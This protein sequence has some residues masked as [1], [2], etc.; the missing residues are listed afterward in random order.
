MPRPLAITI[1]AAL[2]LALGAGPASALTIQAEKAAV[3]TVGGMQKGAWS[4]WSNGEVGDYVRFEKGGT[5]EIVA[6]AFGS[7]AGGGWPLMSVRIDGEALAQATVDKA[8]AAEYPFK[9]RIEPGTHLVTIGFENDLVVGKEDRNLYLVQIEVRPTEGLPEPAAAD[10]KE[11]DAMQEKEEAAAVA[12]TRQAI[13]KNRRSALT[14]RVVDRDGRAVPGASVTAEQTASDFLFGCNIYMFDRFGKPEQNAAYQ[15]RFEELF[16]YATVGFYWTSY[17]TERGKPQYP[18]TDKVVAWCEAR[19][20][21]MKGH[22]LLWADPQGGVPPWSKGQPSA[23]LQKQRVFDILGRY[24]DKITFWEVVNEAC[25]N[26]GVKIDDPYRWAR[27]ADPKGHLIV[28]EYYVMADGYPAFYQFLEGAKARGVPFD[29]IGIQAHEPRTDRF[30]LGRVQKVLDRYAA[31]GKTVSITEFTPCSGGDAIT[32]S[33]VQGKWDEAA[34]AD[35]AEKFYRV[36]FAHPAVI[37]VTWWDL[38]DA[39]AWLKGGGLLRD[40]LSP[41]PAYEALRRLVREE[42][43]THAEGKTDATGAL[44]LRGFH[45]QYRLTAVAGDRK[46]EAT[47]HLAK[48]GPGEVVIKMP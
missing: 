40:D 35:Y 24:K 15:K 26:A 16:N 3:H 41:K 19:G 20:I 22:P 6:R 43:H 1:L 47:F 29:G 23:D 32:G 42:W 30:P 28:N 14:V 21:R 10:R 4:I 25:H 27:E 31:L 48:D 9:V 39:G 5:Y 7:P 13:E 33:H 34:Q 17:E 36:C 38:A 44:A 8:E 11:L 2:L 37:A 18:Y 12:A 46:A 45:G